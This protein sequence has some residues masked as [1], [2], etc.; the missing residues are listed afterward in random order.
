MDYQFRQLEERQEEHAKQSDAR[1]EAYYK[2]MDELLR[3]KSRRGAA[4]PVSGFESPIETE[5]GSRFFKKEKRKRRS[6]S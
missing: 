1:S 3:K 5:N 6:T 4:M 2:R